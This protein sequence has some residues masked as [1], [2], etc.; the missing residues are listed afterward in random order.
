MV[1]GLAWL[2]FGEAVDRYT[3]IGAAI[4]IGASLYIARREARVAR[5]KHLEPVVAK[6]EPQA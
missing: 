2:L 5:E 3:A 1:A 6:G 4:V